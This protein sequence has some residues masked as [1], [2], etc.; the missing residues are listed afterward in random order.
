M[1]S[2]FAFRFG[3]QLFENGRTKFRLWAPSRQDVVLQIEGRPDQ[4]MVAS[5]DGWRE[6]E[7]FCRPGT[8]YRF[9]AGDT[10]FPDPASRMQA[11]D[12][13]DWSVVVDSSDYEWHCVGWKGRPWRETVI[14]ELHPGL[15]G[16]FTG[17]REQLP[18]LR[19]V[20][21]TAIELMPIADFPG[22]RN[23]GYDGVLPYAP[24]RAYGEPNELRALI[25]DAH[26][27][28]LMVFLDV[29][30]NHFGPDGNY[31][32]V[33]APQFFDETKHT[34]WGAAINFAEPNVR[35]FFIENALYWLLE[36]RFDGLRFDAVHAILDK[37]F[38]RELARE[39][40]A[41]IPSDRHIHLV[42]ENDNNDSELLRD[43]YTAQ[44][45]DDLHHVLHV[46]LTGETDGYYNDYAEAPAEK[47]ARALVRGFVYQGEESPFRG[48]ER[49]GKSTD[50]LGPVSFVSFL[51][52]H[53]QIG[54]RAFGERLTDLAKPEALEAAIALLLLAPQIPLIFM[55]EEVGAREPFLYFTDHRDV[56]LAE[57]VKNGRRQEFAKF[58]EFA[59]ERKRASIPDPNAPETFERSRPHFA[60]NSRTELYKRL[61]HVR[62]E[63]I[64]PLANEI[65][66]A[67]AHAVGE[68]T[69][70]AKWRLSAGRSLTIACNLGN[71]P[72]E[73]VLPESMPIW[74]EPARGE[75]GAA[76]TLAWVEAP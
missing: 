42:L 25:D 32:G 53:D 10:A 2:P 59:D 34:P 23:W 58:P 47:L 8:R 45:N 75:L 19:D 30:Y 3:P 12:V 38:L 11:R 72:V 56:S 17:I 24:D 13:H 27:H 36:F 16:G 41:H 21:V 1:P 14:Y 44:W 76:T 37:S 39:I 29:V 28:G 52:N 35:R 68:H 49:R 74:G 40:R 54:N 48:G 51:Q 33:Y 57:T 5:D 50:G 26:A 9:R 55:G 60:V 67:E 62:R 65:H 70:L 7:A 64:M 31:L 71:T 61:L 20:G 18:R 73:A 6:A 4:P 15:L 69:V 22:E 66:S 43:G 63:T 46:L